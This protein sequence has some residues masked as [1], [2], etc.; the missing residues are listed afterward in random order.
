MITA[1]AGR[2]EGAT[3]YSYGASLGTFPISQG[4]QLTDDGG[5]PAPTLINGVLHQGPT[6]F[7]GLQYWAQSGIPLD[8]ATETVTMTGTLEII[9]STFNEGGFDR[10]GYD[11][12]VGDASGR[13]IV[14]DLTGNSVFLVNDAIN[15]HS[16]IIN[17]NTE[18]R[19][20][21]YTLVINANGGSLFIDNG[22]SPVV[23]E[24]LGPTGQTTPNLV[25]FGDGTILGSNESLTTS[26]R[27]SVSAVPE[28]SARD[29]ACVGMLIGLGCA[30]GRRQQTDITRGRRRS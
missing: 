30:M 26:I 21:T 9:S 6:S 18:G 16:P 22:L 8:F 25:L 3:I 10:G 1:F 29:L 13:D 17:F 24:A 19:F 2:G 20:H 23:T 5:S 14:L 4:W 28:P 7:S 12:S 15:S 11:F 27:V